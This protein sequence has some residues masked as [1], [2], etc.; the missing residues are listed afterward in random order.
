MKLLV[1]L[2][3]LGF[4]VLTVDGTSCTSGTDISLSLLLYEINRILKLQ[5]FSFQLD[6]TYFSLL[7]PPISY[8]FTDSHLNCLYCMVDLI[9]G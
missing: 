3:C 1:L 9:Y 2:D 6:R 4:R 5:T 7:I 8:V